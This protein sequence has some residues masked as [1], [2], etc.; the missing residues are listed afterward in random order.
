[1]ETTIQHRERF[2]SKIDVGKEDDCWEYKGAI[3]STG[4]GAFSIGRKNIKAHRFAYEI[5][6]GEIPPGMCVC[7]HCD[8]GKCCNPKHLF[9]G[10]IKDNVA[11]MISKGR[12]KILYGENDPKSKLK[13]KEVLEIVRLYKTGKVSQFKLADMFRVNRT[14]IEGILFG[15]IWRRTTGINYGK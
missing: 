8:N 12:K 7:H 1:M 9:L 10:T 15:R 5:E 11:D 13:E 2:L 6:Y 4:R 14:T 3:N